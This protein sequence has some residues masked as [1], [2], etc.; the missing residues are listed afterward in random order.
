MY[1]QLCPAAKFI[2]FQKNYLKIDLQYF[3]KFLVVVF[4]KKLVETFLIYKIKI[5]I[6]NI[7]ILICFKNIVFNLYPMA[8]R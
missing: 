6:C 3:V 5:K 8:V 7:K 2:G 1:I 4:K